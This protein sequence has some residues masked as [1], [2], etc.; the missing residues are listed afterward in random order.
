MGTAT[1]VRRPHAEYP[2]LSSAY[3]AALLAGG[4]CLRDGPIGRVGLELEA[5]CFDLSDLSR[6]PAWAELT[7]AVAAV[8]QLPGGSAIT[9]E[10]GGA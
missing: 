4:G 5:H 10:P 1:A 3:S 8:P 9:M 6:R 7:E 2:Q